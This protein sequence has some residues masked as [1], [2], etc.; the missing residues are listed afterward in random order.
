MEVF[1]A[2]QPDAQTEEAVSEADP[3]SLCGRNGGVGHRRRLFDQALEAAQAHGQ[4]EHVGARDDGPDRLSEL[5]SRFR[6]R[7]VSGRA[8]TSHCSR[9]RVRTPEFESIAG[10]SGF[11][12]QGTDGPAFAVTG[13]WS[14]FKNR[15]TLWVE[16]SCKRLRRSNLTP[17]PRRYRLNSLKVGPLQRARVLLCLRPSP[18]GIYSID[19][20]LCQNG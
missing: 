4:P 5:G 14:G 1:G 7:P 13:C 19:Y 6:S 8:I 15:S 2:L 16:R 11:M 20:R 10:D 17:S 12:A 3:P 18:G 9:V